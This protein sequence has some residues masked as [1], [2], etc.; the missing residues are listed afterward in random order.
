M[1]HK[2]RCTNEKSKA[3]HFKLYQNI[4]AN[5]GWENWQMIP[6]EKY[7]CDD[8][9]QA[10]IREQYWIGQLQSKLNEK[11]AFRTQEEIRTYDTECSKKYY[12]KN[13]IKKCEYQKEY[14]NLNI[15]TIRT[16]RQLPNVKYNANERQKQKCTCE[17]G[18]KY[19]Y[20]NKSNHIKTQTHLHFQIQ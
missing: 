2:T 5:G 10:C 9:I 4:R 13:Q 20:G 19:T 15:E 11:K 18:G 6:L 14:Y 12:Y 3:Y 16:Y 8:K 17:C 7:P 1:D